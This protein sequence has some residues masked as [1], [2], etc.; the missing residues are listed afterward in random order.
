LNKDFR[1]HEPSRIFGVAL[2]FREVFSLG[3]FRPYSNPDFAPLEAAEKAPTHKVSV[4]ICV[5]VVAIRRAFYSYTPFLARRNVEV[6]VKKAGN[7]VDKTLVPAQVGL[8]L[9]T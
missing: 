8:N 5:I 1:K 3:W 4:K 9:A 2:F 7:L 6:P